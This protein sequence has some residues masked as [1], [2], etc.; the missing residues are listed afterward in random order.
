MNANK[1]LPISYKHLTIKAKEFANELT[2][3]NVIEKNLNTPAQIVKEHVENKKAVS[4]I[5]LQRGVKRPIT[6][7]C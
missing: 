4:G 6:G 1:R 7:R 3:H 5:L 2:R